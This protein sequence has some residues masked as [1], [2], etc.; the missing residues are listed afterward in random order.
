LPAV[1]PGDVTVT[2]GKGGRKKFQE[3]LH[4]IAGSLMSRL[5][6]GNLNQRLATRIPEFGRFLNGDGTDTVSELQEILH[7][8]RQLGD[9]LWCSPVLTGSGDA[10]THV[11]NFSWGIQPQ[12]LEPRY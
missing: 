11:H 3:S 12:F 1:R 6:L 5:L 9:D 8:Q 10:L 4:R 2:G 7:T